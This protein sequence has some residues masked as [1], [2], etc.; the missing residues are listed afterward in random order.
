MVL[1]VSDPIGQRVLRLTMQDGHSNRLSQELF[2]YLRDSPAEASSSLRAA[3]VPVAPSSSLRSAR[4]T[5]H[6]APSTRMTNTEGKQRIIVFV[7]GGM[8]YAEMRLAYT[9]GRA[10]G[11][12][13][14]IGAY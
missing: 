13:I 8:T 6:K 5:W 1:E 9:V 14:F 3:N 12:E 2:P 4:P 7:A 10:L 11:K